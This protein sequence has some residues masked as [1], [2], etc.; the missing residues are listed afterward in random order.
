MLSVV[1]LKRKVQKKEEASQ[2]FLKTMKHKCDRLLNES[3]NEIWLSIEWENK[4]VKI[5]R[6]NMHS[7]E[8][9]KSF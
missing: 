8:K 6:Q 5:L 1:Y 9:N 3:S 7:N 2:N 4:C